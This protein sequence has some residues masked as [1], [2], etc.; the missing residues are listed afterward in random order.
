[1]TSLA[2][3]SSRRPKSTLAAWVVAAVA[4]SLIGFGVAKTLSPSVNVVSGTESARAQ[5]L[6]TA[7]SGPSQLTPILLAGPKASLDRQERGGEEERREC[8]LVKLKGHP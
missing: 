4:L 7:K 2:Q 6:A 5:A 8:H 3:L 1:M